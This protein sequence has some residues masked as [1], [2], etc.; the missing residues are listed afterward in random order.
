[1]EMDRYKDYLNHI[2]GL[3]AE[4]KDRII[5]QFAAWMGFNEEKLRMRKFHRG[6]NCPHCCAP[7]DQIVCYG[8]MAGNKRRRYYCKQC[9][10]TFN[11]RTGSVHHGSHLPEKW[12]AYLGF[13][14]E[15]L[16][17]RECAR[18]V[19]ISPTTSTAWRHKILDKLM[20]MPSE[21]LEGI[22]EVHQYTPLPTRKGQSRKTSNTP[23][24]VSP[25]VVIM[26]IDR[27][28]QAFVGT[29]DEFLRLYISEHDHVAR[30]WVASFETSL[31]QIPIPVNNPPR[32]I[33]FQELLNSPNQVHSLAKEYVDM[34][35]HRMRGVAAHNQKRYA[36]WQRFLRSTAGLR[37]RDRLDK[38][39]VSLL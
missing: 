21:N 24:P 5:Q 11:D 8:S 19:G 22:I 28:K 15:G 10:H 37:P 9:K 33:A 6:P 4:R 3:P 27:R 23:G 29:C 18:K 35:C 26:A 39:L 12:P 14:L 34:T 38:M 1:M 17:I 31:D 13:M 36:A 25:P 30:Q 2:K 7:H 16:S 20:E 32:S